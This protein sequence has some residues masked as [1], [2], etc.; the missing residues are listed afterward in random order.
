LQRCLDCER[1]QFYPRILCCHCGGR[2]LEWRAVS[3]R[4]RVASYTVVHRAVS[5]AYATP[6]T[7]LLVDLDE[8]PRMMSSLVGDDAAAVQVGDAVSVEFQPWSE[9]VALPV[10][11][12][13]VEEKT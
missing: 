4:G 5:A 13:I 12:R 6:A 2:R 8:G 11:R 10:F 9:G 3:G 7:I 1:F